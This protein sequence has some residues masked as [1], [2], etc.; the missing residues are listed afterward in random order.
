MT[1]RLRYLVW[2]ALAL[3]L[4]GLVVA[5]SGLISVG[6]SSGHWAITNVALHWAMQQSVETRALSVEPPPNLDDP[7][8]VRRA[9]RHFETSCAFCHGSPARDGR[10]LPQQMTP[11][12]PLLTRSAEEWTASELFVIVKHGVKFS[13]MPAWI[14]LARDDEVW[15][16]VSFL[17]ALPR[18]DAASYLSLV[19]VP[20]E[21]AAATGDPVIQNCMACHGAD[22]GSQDGAFPVIAGQ[23]LAYLR[24][25]LH[26]FADKRRESGI[27]QFAAA[28]LSRD[29]L[30]R[31]ARYYAA[32][33]AP[34]PA[35]PERPGSAEGQVI[36]TRGLPEARV[37]PC[38][39]CHR[40]GEVENP[41]FPLL[42]GQEGWYL[43]AQLHLWKDHARGGTRY[44]HLM[45]KVVPGLSPADIEAVAAHFAAQSWRPAEPAREEAAK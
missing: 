24:E 17:R 40:R 23:R 25:S 19:G 44:A 36:A 14:S 1:I 10:A 33:P 16:M 31:A 41:V 2:A 37:P 26:A 21:G 30:E 28:G 3:A 22:G 18:L 35:G 45:D 43:E 7:A 12:P 34:E 29:D 6:A 4:A 8:L 38:G 32:L 42:D 13:G 39:R 20:P 27:M 11:P 15:A 5:W 9:A